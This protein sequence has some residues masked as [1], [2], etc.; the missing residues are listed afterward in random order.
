[1][2]WLIKAQKAEFDEKARR[3]LVNLEATL[4]YGPHFL[5]MWMDA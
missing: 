4:G 1:M 2:D 3:A 5:E